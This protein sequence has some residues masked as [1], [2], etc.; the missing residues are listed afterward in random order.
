MKGSA[1]QSIPRWRCV[2]VVLL[3]YRP[4]ALRDV[5]RSAA[6][7]K[8]VALHIPAAGEGIAIAAQMLIDGA[9]DI[10]FIS[11]NETCMR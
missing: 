8:A 9:H 10:T 11:R 1:R 5:L 3:A 2:V 7:I 4:L 6:A